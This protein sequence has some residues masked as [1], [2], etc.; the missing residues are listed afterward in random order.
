M[1]K[2]KKR[3]IIILVVVFTCFIYLQKNSTYTS[4]ESEVEARVESKVADWKIK[5]NNTLITGENNQSIDIDTAGWETEHTMDGTASPG[6]SG[7]ITIT[8]D[9]TTT[10]VPFDYTLTIIDHTINPEKILT[11]TKIE[12]TLTPLVKKENT[13]QGTMTL[14]DI[15]RKK[16]DTI[17]IHAF[18]DDGGQD[19][20]VNSDEETQSINMIEI[21]F[22]A[23]QKK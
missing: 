4:Y 22:R 13:Y 18:W 9:P 10:E 16:I 11:V 17:K 8:V 6:T 2:K 1:I 7:I 3:L 21:D 19:I 14:N 15:K 23:S 12:N 5:V 20:E